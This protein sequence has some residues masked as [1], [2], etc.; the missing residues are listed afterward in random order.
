MRVLTSRITD[1]LFATDRADDD[2]LQLYILGEELDYTEEEVESLT[3]GQRAN[4]RRR[5]FALCSN[6][7]DVLSGPCDMNVLWY[8]AISPVPFVTES[9]TISMQIAYDL[10]GEQRYMGVPLYRDLSYVICPTTK[11]VLPFASTG[12]LGREM[13]IEHI[14]KLVDSF[15]EFYGANGPFREYLDEIVGARELFAYLHMNEGI[16]D[17]SRSKNL[18]SR[19]LCRLV[20]L[21]DIILGDKALCSD[22]GLPEKLHEEYKKVQEVLA[23]VIARPIYSMSTD[24]LIALSQ[25]SLPVELKDHMI[26]WNLNV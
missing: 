10:E 2:V 15:G 7:P 14:K 20:T 24:G 6:S 3:A 23:K 5:F 12:F 16:E 25:E 11:K 1:T 21:D 26:D 22:V 9:Y 4:S 8:G 17:F 18:T 19:M 13:E